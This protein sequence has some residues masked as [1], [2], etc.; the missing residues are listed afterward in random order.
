[1]IAS[2]DDKAGQKY[3]IYARDFEHA[4]VVIRTQVSCKPQVYADSTG[5]VVPL[6]SPMRPLHRDGSLGAAVSS[7]TLRQ[8]EAAILFK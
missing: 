7:I 3:Q 2:G 8:V 4:Y 5:V 1:M 6:P